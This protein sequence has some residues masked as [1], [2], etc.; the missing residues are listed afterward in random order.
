V[1]QGIT[2]GGFMSLPRKGYM[3]KCIVLSLLLLLPLVSRASFDV[4]LKYGNKGASVTEVQEFLTDQNYYSGP[5]TGNFFTLTL[6]GVKK[7][8]KAQGLKIT[9]IWGQGERDVANQISGLDSSNTVALNTPADSFHFMDW[10]ASTTPMSVPIDVCLNIQGAQ[11]FVPN[12][13]ITDGQ[14]NC[15][16]PVSS[17]NP[18]PTPTPTPTSTPVATYCQDTSAPNY[19]ELSPCLPPDGVCHNASRAD[20]YLKLPCVTTPP[21]CGNGLYGTVN[22]S[23]LHKPADLKGF[24]YSF[25][26]NLGMVSSSRTDSEEMISIPAGNITTIKLQ[27][28]KGQ[29][30]KFDDSIATINPNGFYVSSCSAINVT[31]DFTK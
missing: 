7:F 15:V 8:Q 17:Y 5:I 14:G 2:G 27:V 24:L 16:V 11:T 20:T 9:G 28:D 10:T 31:I 13:M 23:V 18:A 22:V 30:W 26:Q 4:N 29:G 19:G 1:P 3:K 6:Q 25:Y 21:V 12:G